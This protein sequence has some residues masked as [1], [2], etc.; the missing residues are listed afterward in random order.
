MALFAAFPFVLRLAANFLWILMK[1]GVW[2]C[3]AAG[4]FIE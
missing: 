2:G 3:C 1:S 4:V